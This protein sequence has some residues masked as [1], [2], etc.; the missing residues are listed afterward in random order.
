MSP[1]VTLTDTVARRSRWSILLSSGPKQDQ[2]ANDP[3]TAAARPC[4][5]KGR[6][7]ILADENTEIIRQAR[8]GLMSGKRW[9]GRPLAALNVP[10]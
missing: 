6:T 9:G 7:A 10:G 8:K 2:P 5:E 1:F 3:T 4:T